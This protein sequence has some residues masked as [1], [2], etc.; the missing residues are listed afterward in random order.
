MPNPQVLFGHQFQREGSLTG[1]LF[2]CHAYQQP[3]RPFLGGQFGYYLGPV[4]VTIPQT[5]HFHQG[6]PMSSFNMGY[7]EIG[8]ESRGYEDAN[9]HVSTI[10]TVSTVAN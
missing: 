7:P 2:A 9:S 5:T 8:H 4:P 1:P 10:S 6:D 3:Y